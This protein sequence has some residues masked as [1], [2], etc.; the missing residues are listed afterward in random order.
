[1]QAAGLELDGAAEMFRC[2]VRVATLPLDERGNELNAAVLG[3]QKARFPEPIGCLFRLTPL[4]RDQAEIG[5]AGRLPGGELG[6]APERRRGQPA[7]ANLGGGHAPVERRDRLRVSGR[8]GIGQIGA[9]AGGGTESE[10]EDG[11]KMSCESQRG[12]TE[13]EGE[14]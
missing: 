12:V 9:L 11:G 6:D 14:R 13:S 4:E 3:R 7:L 2:R 5:P 10:Q 8:R 1:M